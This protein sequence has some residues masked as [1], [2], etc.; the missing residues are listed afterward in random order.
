[1]E[2]IEVTAKAAELIRKLRDENYLNKQK[3][4]LCDAYSSAT[5][6]M[7]DNNYSD[8]SLLPLWAIQCYNELMDELAKDTREFNEFLNVVK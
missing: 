3:S 1:M 7:Q 4:M 6:Y 2:N 8:I 5:V